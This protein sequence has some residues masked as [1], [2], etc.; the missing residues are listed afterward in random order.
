MKKFYILEQIEL[1]KKVQEDDDEAHSYEDGLREDF[2]EYIAKR[3][4]DIGELA[5]LVLSTNKID[6]NRRCG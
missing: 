1:I 3:S 5:R 6:F 4:D 2:I